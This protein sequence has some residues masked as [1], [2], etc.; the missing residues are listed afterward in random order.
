MLT[1]AATDSYLRPG[2]R[3]WRCRPAPAD[4]PRFHRALDGYRP[5]PLVEL[6]A[7]AAEVGVGRLFVKDESDRFGLP[8]FKILGASWAIRQALAD[9]ADGRP[10]TL[11]AATEGNHGRAVARVARMLR[12]PAHIFVPRTIGAASAT[13][14]RSE[15]AT[16]T[17]VPDGYDET[18]RRAAAYAAGDPSRLLIQDTAWPGYE[19]VPAWIVEGYSTLF[20]EVDEQLAAAGAAPAALVGV[21][22]G[23]GSLAQAAVVHH[24]DGRGRPAALLG[25][26]PAVAGCVTASLRAG[27]LTEVPT[28]TTVLAGLNCGVPS[29]LAWPYLRDGLDA[30]TTVSDDDAVRARADLAALGVPAGPSGAAPLAG[31]RAMRHHTG[32]GLNRASTVVL[33]STDG[34]AGRPA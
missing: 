26:E 17:T 21:P 27:T 28:G 32:L 6:P 33:L 20:H 11:V 8:A 30:A 15:G 10:V 1:A 34:A 13:A 24:R 4:V 25:V 31:L 9:R 22:V 18:V 14:I 19:Q 5:T 12:R 29:S 2:A 16:V 7:L 3:A 23:V